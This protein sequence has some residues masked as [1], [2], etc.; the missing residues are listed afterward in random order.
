[1]E[2]KERQE[3]RGGEGKRMLAP[4]AKICTDTGG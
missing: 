3:E 1:V 4:V 2:G